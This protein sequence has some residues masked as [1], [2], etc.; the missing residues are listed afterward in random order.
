MEHFATLQGEG[1]HSGK[2]AYFIRT[3]GCDV[4][5]HWCDVK[6]SWNAEDHL[7]LS[8]A[9]WSK[10]IAGI[11]LPTVVITG[12]EP[13]MYDLEPLTRLIKAS[14]KQVHLETSGVYPLTGAWDWITFSPKKFKS[15]H[16]DVYHAAHELKVVI[17]HPSD[18]EFAEYHASKVNAECKLYV[19]PEWSKRE[20]MMPLIV[21]YIKQ[22]PKWRVSLQS[23]KYLNIP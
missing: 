2:A 11:E 8:D 12:G 3:G 17:F 14:G 13:T 18:L 21:D 10:L 22:H 20:S 9:D 23:H 5:C 1:Y 4:G 15:P 7:A 6:E 19:Q 16:S